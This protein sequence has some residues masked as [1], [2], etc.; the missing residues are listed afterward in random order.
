MNKLARGLMA[1]GMALGAMLILSGA[2]LADG[3][4]GGGGAKGG[5]RTENS[6]A[7]SQ[8]MLTGTLTPGAQVTAT[9]TNNNEGPC[10]V[11]LAVYKVYSDNIDNQ[12]LFSQ[13]YPRTVDAGKTITLSAAAPPCGYQA[14]T[15]QG[16]MISSFK[17]GDRYGERLIKYAN[18]YDESNF[19][20]T[21]PPPPPPTCTLGTSLT[22]QITIS[23]D[24]ATAL[25]TN[26]TDEAQ[27]VG[28]ASYAASGPAL[29][30][31][32]LF[33]SAPATV[34]P[35]ST[36]QLKVQLP[37]C[38]YQVDLFTGAVIQKLSS[39]DQYGSRKLD[40]KNNI[41]S[42]TYCKTT[43]PP[44]PGGGGVGGNTGGNT[45]NNGGG[46]GG[47]TVPTGGQGGTL[48]ATAQ[49]PTAG[50]GGVGAATALAET[51]AP[52]ELAILGALLLCLGGALAL[53]SRRLNRI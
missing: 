51:G 48:A 10:Q 35:C 38:S 7:C 13:D 16:A 11:G 24:L 49:A 26:G 23:G 2:T 50:F 46:V 43:T 53:W 14:D 9:I 22:G 39:E 15:F 25:V 8:N 29:A 12:T 45:G 32:T 52:F 31:Q 40:F 36:L 44:T 27:Q 47:G 17:G 21:T 20:T 33:G 18:Q 30:D 1:A 34:Q 4:Q 5:N 37:T 42:A 41:T 3:N 28:L 6:S 19:C